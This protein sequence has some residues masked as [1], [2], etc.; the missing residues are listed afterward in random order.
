M[1]LT[2]KDRELIIWFGKARRIEEFAV[3]E[4]ISYSTA[5][6]KLKVLVAKGLIV[7]NI[8]KPNKLYYKTNPNLLKLNK[9]PEPVLD[10]PKLVE[11]ECGCK[12]STI[13]G[14]CP[15]CSKD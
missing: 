8:F 12:Y 11:C 5:A 14:E 15:V 2:E 7:A 13:L 9:N 4:S 3:K 6:Q 10:E 1:E